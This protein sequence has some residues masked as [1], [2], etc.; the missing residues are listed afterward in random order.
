MMCTDAR[1]RI[2]AVQGLASDGDSFSPPNYAISISE[3]YIQVAAT[4][5]KTRQDLKILHSSPPRSSTALDGVVLPSWVPDWGQ[6]GSPRP[7][8]PEI[9]NASLGRKSQ[10]HYSSLP[11]TALYAQGVIWDTITGIDTFPTSHFL[12]NHRS[13]AL[14]AGN[15]R[16]GLLDEY[17]EAIARSNQD[18]SQRPKVLYCDNCCGPI[19]SLHYHCSICEG[20]D[21]NL[22]FGCVEDG[23]WCGGDSHELI[24]R[25]IINNEVCIGEDTKLSSVIAQ[26]KSK[27]PVEGKFNIF[28]FGCRVYC[29][30]LIDRM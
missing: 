15:R 6:V 29:Y 19:L 20:G 23:I 4:M 26:E 21:F 5:A 9:Y 17:K 14:A 25:R 3:L 22:C 11:S 16:N 7:L 2:Y 10:V 28:Q 24:K 27:I 18:A 12:T 30:I 13:L 1:D 8:D